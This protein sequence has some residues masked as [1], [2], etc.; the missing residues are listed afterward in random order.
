[1][2]RHPRA[3]TALEQY[4]DRLAVARFISEVGAFAALG[5]AQR[6]MLAERVEPLAVGAGE[7][8]ISAGARGDSCYLLR[9]G[10]VE[11][12]RG[13]PAAQVDT[14]GPGAIFGESALLTGAPRSATVR[15]LEPSELLVVSRDAVVEA[16][17]QDPQLAARMT[18]LLRLRERPVRADGVLVE[19]RTSAEGEPTA[20]LKDPERLAYY[21]LS[22]LGL[23]VWERLDGSRNVRELTLEY[24]REHH[25]FAPHAIADAV[26]GLAA[27]G[28]VRVGRLQGDLPAAALAREGRIDRAAR[29][30][31]RVLEWRL[32]LGDL[33]RPVGSIYDRF[34][35]PLF[36][37]PG[38]LALAALAVAGVAAFVATA[39]RATAALGDSAVPL[40]A[41]IPALLLA[42]FV[43][44]AGHAFT[45]KHFG[46][47]VPRAGVGWYW[48]GPIAFVDTS[49]MWLASR[50]QRIL[51]SLA[52]PYAEALFAGVLALAALLA[53]DD[54]VAAA[55]W[56]AT[57]P[58]Y[59]SV[60][61]NF[62][63]LLEFDG[64]YILSDLL[65]RPNLRPRALTW[66]G[67]QLPAALRDR[68]RLRGHRVELL[69][70]LASLAYV[71]AMALLTLFLYR[72]TLEAALASLV[73]D[74]AAQ[75][76][77]W[78]FA[79]A[80]AVLAI[81]ASIGDLR[82]HSMKA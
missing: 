35:W 74:T 23:F 12:L 28:F 66:I 22:A 44:E 10:R 79:T 38:Q 18:D 37:R 76:I 59:I 46:R 53:A 45:T 40:V 42:I 81:C 15:A 5:D 19:R 48:F 25:V 3:E 50:R 30:A 78:V 75:A 24:M 52:G 72:A 32:Y 49:D 60:L 39:G 29:L 8:I 55:L 70:G 64:Y 1:M 69:Y 20:V 71:I 77:G 73:G 17:E 51:V 41:A 63:P 9:R 21:R 47:D 33:D 16:M 14:L 54:R 13:E 56:S 80:T 26:A 57:L 58:L 6:R 2:A 31:R 7:E 36:T 34:L 61:L 4:A 67:Q 11:V 68:D 82:S 43:H 62:N 27:A 65:D